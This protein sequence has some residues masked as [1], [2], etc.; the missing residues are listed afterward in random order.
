MSV[1]GTVVDIIKRHFIS[2]V[3]VVVPLILTYW[4]LAFLFTA[5]DGML[6]PLIR[7]LIGYYTPGLGIITTILL[8]MLAGFF[9]RNIVG[10]RLYAVGDRLLIRVPLIRPIYLSAKQVLAALTKGNRDTFK[11]VCLLEYPRQG[12]WVMGF[13]SG[14][15]TADLGRGSKRY[16]SVFIGSTPTPV[17]GWTVVVPED[18]LFRVNMTIEE[19]VKFLVSGGVVAP[20]KFTASEA[21][22]SQNTGELQG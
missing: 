12:V 21:S 2:G 9:T 13:I 1:L 5:V 15:S 6:E 10:A 20:E 22:K 7:S 4:V 11:E 17:T 8:I 18:E 16:A 19:G 14:Y 3:L